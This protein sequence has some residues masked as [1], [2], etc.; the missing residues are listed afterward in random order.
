MEDRTVADLMV[1][2]KTPYEPKENIPEFSKLVRDV[3]SMIG[4]SYEKFA[5]HAGIN[6]SQV[7]AWLSRKDRSISKDDV[8]LVA[9]ALAKGIDFPDSAPEVDHGKST[10]RARLDVLLNSLLNSAGYKSFTGRLE[11]HIWNRLTATESHVENQTDNASNALTVG[12]VECPPLSKIPEDG[13]PEKPRGLAI[14]VTELVCRYIG[15]EVQWKKIHWEDIPVMLRTGAIDLVAPMT[16]HVPRRLLEYRLSEPLLKVKG[17]IN[18]IIHHDKKKYVLR[19]GVAVDKRNI[20]IEDIDIDK[21]IF[22]YNPKVLGHYCIEVLKYELRGSRRFYLHSPEIQIDSRQ[23]AD[24]KSVITDPEILPTTSRRGPIDSDYKDDKYVNNPKKIRCFMAGQLN[25]Q[26]LCMESPNA[27]TLFG[28]EHT[29]MKVPYAFAMFH[30]ESK[31]NMIIDRSLKILEDNQEIQKLIDNY[32]EE[33]A[34]AGLLPSK[35]SAA[36]DKATN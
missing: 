16:L 36:I 3:L 2:L 17:G 9:W 29:I 10:G 15:V 22:E 8:C 5:E 33:L 20:S 14:G 25:C 18:C 4:W 35:H 32:Q 34:G 12:Y 31:L 7:R 11:D 28:P 21:I 27:T 1:I 6:K 24:W 13:N 26:N 23:L 30:T 19:E